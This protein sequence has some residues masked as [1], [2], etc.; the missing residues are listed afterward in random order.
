LEQR[1]V[2]DSQSQTKGGSF[3]ERFQV[4]NG[5]YEIHLPWR[6]YGLEVPDHFALCSSRL[7][8]LDARLLKS[9]DLL[10]KYHTIIQE[11]L[12]KGIVEMVSEDPQDVDTPVHYLPHHGVLCHDKQTTKLRIVFNGSAKTKMDPLSLNDCL[13]TGPNMIPKLFDIVALSWWH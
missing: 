13:K 1:V 2:D 8:L 11:Q 6:D 9:P 10:D 7:R 4:N 5:C 12:K 3:L